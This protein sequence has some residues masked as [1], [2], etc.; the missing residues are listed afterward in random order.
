MS[1]VLAE[2]LRLLLVAAFDAL[3]GPGTEAEKVARIER[4]AIALGSKRA[5]EALIDEALK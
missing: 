1:A 5:S 4:A 3:R 2:A